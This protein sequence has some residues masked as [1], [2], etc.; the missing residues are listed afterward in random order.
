MRV[1][2]RWRFSRARAQALAIELAP[3]RIRERGVRVG[4]AE[5]IASVI[6]FVAD[7]WR[8]SYMTGDSVAADGGVVAGLSSE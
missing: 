5:E 1:T 6:L 2:S 7:G 3:A 8:S 4:R